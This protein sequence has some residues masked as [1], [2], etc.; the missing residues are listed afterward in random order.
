MIMVITVTGKDRPGIISS[1]TEVLYRSQ[2]NLEDASMTILEG[3]FAMIFLAELKN[4]SLHTKFR[5]E[6]K[7][8]EKK[9]NLVIFIKE[10][11]HRVTRGEKHR[12]GTIPWVVSVLGKDKAGIVY[13]VSKLLADSGLNITDLNSK[14]IG[15][16]IKTTYVLILEVDIPRKNIHL[17]SQLK[18]KFKTI[19]KKLGLT[20]AFNPLE[21]SRF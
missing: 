10:I 1:L 4:R 5:Q 15:R 7:K 3:E 13:R 14:I 19:E 17:I 18:R 12:P 16:G 11:K 6:L 2:G 20:V 9:L 21:S 8:L